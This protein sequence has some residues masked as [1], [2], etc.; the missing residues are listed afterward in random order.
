MKG[1]RRSPPE[2]VLVVDIHDRLL[3]L[4]QQPMVARHFCIVLVDLPVAISPVVE[5]A[6]RDAEPADK[7]RKAELGAV[8]TAW[9]ARM[10]NRNNE[11]ICLKVDGDRLQRPPSSPHGR[12]PFGRPRPLRTDGGQRPDHRLVPRL[13]T[14]SAKKS[15][16]KVTNR[17]DIF[18]ARS[19]AD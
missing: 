3:L 14:A 6:A 17:C 10:C 5:L 9:R 2:R 11:T 8:M 18:C 4:G 7:P 13:F 16:R 12:A 15:P 19:L 1:G